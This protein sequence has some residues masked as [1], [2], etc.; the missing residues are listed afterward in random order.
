MEQKVTPDFFYGSA[1]AALI[2]LLAGL[3][4]HG[5]WEN[6]ARAPQIWFSSAAAEQLARP[7][8]NTDA[9]AAVQPEQPQQQFADLD[10]G[11]LPPDPLPVTRLAPERFDPRPAASEVER[12]DVDDLAA[13]AAPA[14]AT[15]SLY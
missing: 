13:D 2:G 10:V 3:V 12:E 11:Y 4:L 15:S 9:V 1:L 7:Q 6:H 14:P 8:T 5:P